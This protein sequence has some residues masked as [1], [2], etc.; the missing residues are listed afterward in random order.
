MTVSLMAAPP[1]PEQPWHVEPLPVLYLLRQNLQRSGCAA[2]QDST[3][4]Q[5][6]VPARSVPVHSP[7]LPEL[8]EDVLPSPA[9]HSFLGCSAPNK[10]S[11]K[12]VL[13]GATPPLRIA[14]WYHRGTA[15][16]LPI[17]CA[18]CRSMT[19]LSA[20]P[21]PPSPPCGFNTRSCLS[22]QLNS[23]NRSVPLYAWIFP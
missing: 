5:R 9:A 19:S 14:I 17:A 6:Q 12:T 20:L 2:P 15:L 10:L 8:H 13:R 16:C 18:V 4:R 1:L 11:G 3:L 23:L 7:P 21:Y 22:A